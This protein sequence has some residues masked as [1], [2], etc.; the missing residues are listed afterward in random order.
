MLDKNGGATNTICEESTDFNPHE[1]PLIDIEMPL[2]STG[3]LGTLWI[4]PTPV[5]GVTGGVSGTSK[6]AT[7]IDPG[8]TPSTAAGV[9][10]DGLGEGVGVG[11]GVGET[12]GDG[13]TGKPLAPVKKLTLAV[14]APVTR[15]FS[16]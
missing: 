4:E 6:F 8:E 11:V 5:R 7:T 3:R 1:I 15:G 12:V 16:R 13:V 9:V 14:P 2:N 10:G